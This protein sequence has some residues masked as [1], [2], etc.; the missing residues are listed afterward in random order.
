MKIS[1]MEDKKK[2]KESRIK[3]W[4]LGYEKSKNKAKSMYSKIG[5]MYCPALDND[6]VAFTS[7]GFNHLVRKGRIPRPKNEQKRRFV[8]V[9]YI[10]K[11]I[12]NPQAVILYRRKDIKNVVNRHGEKISVQ[13]VADFWTLIVEIDDCRIKVVFRQLEGGQKQFQSIMGNNVKINKSKRKKNGT[14]KSPR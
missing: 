9:Q 5:R 10:E 11:I 1:S 3:A 12:K 4:N 13:S 2:N 6:I 8:L 7:A 14:K